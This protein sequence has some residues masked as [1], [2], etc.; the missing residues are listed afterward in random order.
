MK[1]AIAADPIHAD[2]IPVPYMEIHGTAE[3]I[4]H[5]PV[6]DIIHA[7][8]AAPAAR[9][10]IRG[11]PAQLPARINPLQAFRRQSQPE[12]RANTTWSADMFMDMT[13]IQTAGET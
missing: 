13:P 3:A 4:E 11:H 7:D 6:A 9:M 10:E 5:A 1:F 2:A 8:A 12:N